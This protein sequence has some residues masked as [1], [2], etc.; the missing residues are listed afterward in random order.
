MKRRFRRQAERVK[1]PPEHRL[2]NGRAHVDLVDA[3]N[4]L[5]GANDVAGFIRN[6]EAVGRADGAFGEVGRRARMREALLVLHA[7]RGQTEALGEAGHGDHHRALFEHLIAGEFGGRIA[8]ELELHALGFV[9]GQAFFA[10]GLRYLGHLYEQRR[11]RQAFHRHADIDQRFLREDAVDHAH[12]EAVEQAHDLLVAQHEFA[13]L[14][15]DRPGFALHHGMAGI[16]RVQV[17]GVVFDLA[18]LQP[19][20]QPFEEELVVEVARPQARVGLAETVQRAGHAQHADEARPGAVEV[21]QQQHRAAMPGQARRQVVRVLPGGEQHDDRRVRIDR[22]EQVAAFALAADEAVAL[23]ALVQV[24]ALGLDAETARQRLLQLGLEFVLYRPAGDVG[25]FTQVGIGDD[26][27]FF[28]AGLDQR[29]RFGK[30][31]LEHLIFLSARVI[32][33][34]HGDTAGTAK[35]P[36]RVSP[37]SLCSSWLIRSS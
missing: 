37:C 18:I 8:A 24:R 23:V 17:R 35:S 34:N 6:R 9:P 30:G 10:Q 16:D 5:A 19:G 14:P 7:H 29:L 20:F 25:R 1:Q 2:R 21:G 31:Q 27:H 3:G 28:I 33:L 15:A 12:A 4:R 22:G 26:Q 11:L 36:I 32:D 13:D